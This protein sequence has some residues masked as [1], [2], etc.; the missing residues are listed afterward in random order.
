VDFT[1]I[2]EEQWTKNFANGFL[3]SSDAS[4]LLKQRHEETRYGSGPGQFITISF[5]N[6]RFDGEASFSGRSFE[7]TADFT[8]ARFYYPPDFDDATKIGRIFLPAKTPY[9]DPR[10]VSQFAY[11]RF[12]KSRRKQKTTISSAI[13]ISRNAKPNAA[14]TGINDSKI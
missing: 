8:G 12:E 9:L 10:A 14:S 7:K 13:S 1:G 4:A 6:A 11:A 3:R 2:S 5:S